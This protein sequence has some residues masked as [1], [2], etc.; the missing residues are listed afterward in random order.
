MFDQKKLSDIDTV[1]AVEQ[2]AKATNY[3]TLEIDQMFVNYGSGYFNKVQES[4][5]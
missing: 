1:L 3:R 4:P 5:K 2:I